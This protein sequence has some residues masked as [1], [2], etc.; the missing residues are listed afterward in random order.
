M[1]MTLTCR[2][3]LLMLLATVISVAG[4]HAQTLRT[5][6]AGQEQQLPV[7]TVCGLGDIF[8]PESLPPA[9]SGPVVFLIALC[10]EPANRQPPFVPEEYLHD[11]HLKPS[12][13][14]RGLWTPYDERAERAI[15]EDYRR[16]WDNHA[17]SDL[18]VDVRDYVFANGV[19]GKIVNYRITERN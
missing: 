4:P 6:A 17:L 1:A 9:S 14:S 12:A 19:I 16:L 18:V 7:K 15:F 2:S 10:P 8:K 5:L 11:I 3:W 13:P